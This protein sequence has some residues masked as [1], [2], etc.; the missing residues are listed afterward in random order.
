MSTARGGYAEPLPGPALTQSTA[1]HYICY[2]RSNAIAWHD[3]RCPTISGRITMG[4]TVTFGIIGAGGIVS[5]LHLPQLSG[6]SD[7]KV[8]RKSVV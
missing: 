3:R 2:N 8:D 4:D 1:V 7:V 6:M 5:K